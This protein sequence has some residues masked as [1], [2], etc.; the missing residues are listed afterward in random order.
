MPLGS[1]SGIASLDFPHFENTTTIAFDGRLDNRADLVRRCACRPDSDALLALAAYQASGLEGLGLLVGDWSL[2]IVDGARREVVLASDYAGVRPLYYS[3]AQGTLR[4]SSSLAE[5]SRGCTELD[6]GYFRQFLTLG[7][8]FDRTPY[9]GVY[10]V[11]PGHAIV[12]RSSGCATTPT[13]R[14]R[15]GAPL[16]FRDTGEYAQRFRTLFEEA[17]AVRLRSSGTVFVELSGGL[18]S[19]A[20]AAMAH[21]LIANGQVA[22]PKAVTLTYRHP[23]SSDERFYRLMERFLGTDSIHLDTG[24]FPF[25]PRSSPAGSA[26]QWWRT[27]HTEVARLLREAVGDVLLTGQL[28]D[29][30]M[31]NWVDDS[32]QVGDLIRSGSF[33]RAIRS[34]I[35]WAMTTQQPAYSIL[36]RAIEVNIPWRTCPE[37]QAETSLRPGTGFAPA[38]DIWRSASPGRRKHYREAARML[39]ARVLETPEPLSGI[40][41]SHPYSHRPLVEFMLAIPPEIA[42]AP[43]EPRRLMRLALEDLLPSAILARRSK[44]SFQPVF[45]ASLRPLAAELLGKTRPFALEEHGI[46]D[47]KNFK[48]R[49]ERYLHGLECN[50]GQLRVVVLAEC[51]LQNRECPQY[52]FLRQSAAL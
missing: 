27:R 28:G 42:A 52:Q 45:S 48:S 12:A 46:V 31:A 32:D 24:Q 2:A 44:A 39:R 7:G 36:R 29:L 33:Y 18:D 20:I 41:Y 40:L 1:L 23:G 25:L 19:S 34:S 14:L 15:P 16:R 51:W 11:P 9:R 26:P 30:V 4:W 21:R 49:L 13:W 3:F 8:S 5:V 35:E 50:A 43:G 47:G 37:P 22:A 10:K 17:V 6:D 38:D